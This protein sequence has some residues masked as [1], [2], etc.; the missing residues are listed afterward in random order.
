MTLKDPL[1]IRLC[2]EFSAK[3]DSGTLSNTKSQMK[4]SMALL[5]TLLTEERLS[6]SAAVVTRVASFSVC[7][8]CFSQP[9]LGFHPFPIKKSVR[10]IERQKNG[11]TIRKKKKLS[12]VTPKH[13]TSSTLSGFNCLPGQRN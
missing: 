10:L 3:V 9:W 8:V 7:S 12:T 1:R 4:H 2:Q 11:A 13:Y 6:H 5:L